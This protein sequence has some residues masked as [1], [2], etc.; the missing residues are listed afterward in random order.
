MGEERFKLLLTCKVEPCPPTKPVVDVHVLYC[1]H[2]IVESGNVFQPNHF[3]PIVFDNKQAGGLKRKLPA[4][5]VSSNLA[6]A[7]LAAV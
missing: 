3:V 5:K 7:Y 2:G 4:Q 1:F 6:G